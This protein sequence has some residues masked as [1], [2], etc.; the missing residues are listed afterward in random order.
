MEARD[1]EQKESA[2]MLQDLRFNKKFHKKRTI[3]VYMRHIR[4]VN[5][6]QTIDTESKHYF[7]IYLIIPFEHTF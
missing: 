6:S 4:V 5:I 2:D 3:R 7:Q 1:Q